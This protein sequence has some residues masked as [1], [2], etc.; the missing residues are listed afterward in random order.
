MYGCR[1]KG[2]YLGTWSWYSYSYGTS[3]GLDYYGNFHIYDSG[4]F[5]VGMTNGDEDEYAAV[6][7]DNEIFDVEF[8]SNDMEVEYW[9]EL[10]GYYMYNYF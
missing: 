7:W 4:D 10:A 8:M 1:D 6:V 3:W 2:L 9:A 5:T